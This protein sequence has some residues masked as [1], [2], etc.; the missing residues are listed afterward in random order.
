MLLDQALSTMNCVAVDELDK[1]PGR[2][3]R[4]AMH[5]KEASG[6]QNRAT[7]DTFVEHA[8]E[9]NRPN[10]KRKSY[11]AVIAQVAEDRREPEHKADADSAMFELGRLQPHNKRDRQSTNQ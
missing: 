7:V 6:R 9:Q 8:S 4:H 11:W 2:I 1:R 3:E 5:A 10:S